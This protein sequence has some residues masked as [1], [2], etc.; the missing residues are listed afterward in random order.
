MI[1]YS[2]ATFSIATIAVQETTKKVSALFRIF[3]NINAKTGIKSAI[4]VASI[5]VRP[6]E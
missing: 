3:P 5:K 4:Q 6:N 2:I 1:G